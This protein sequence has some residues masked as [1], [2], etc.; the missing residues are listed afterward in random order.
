LYAYC[1]VFAI[2]NLPD[3]CLGKSSLKR[4]LEAVPAGSLAVGAQ[5]VQGDACAVGEGEPAVTAGGLQYRAQVVDRYFRLRLRRG[6]GA[7][8]SVSLRGSSDSAV[9]SAADAGV[10]EVVVARL[11]NVIDGPLGVPCLT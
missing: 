3:D 4:R 5:P 6:F 8:G 10:V 11:S 2:S 1:K 9:S 7:V